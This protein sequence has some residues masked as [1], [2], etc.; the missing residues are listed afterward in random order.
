LGDVTVFGGAAEMQMLG[1]CHENLKLIQIHRF[2]WS[3]LFSSSDT[4]LWLIPLG[5]PVS[6]GLPPWAVVSFFAMGHQHLTHYHL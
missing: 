4:A 5:I 6:T 2:L 3:Q 1:H